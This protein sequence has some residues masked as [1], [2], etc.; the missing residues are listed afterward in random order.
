M[1]GTFHRRKINSELVFGV[2]N[3]VGK[4]QK[5]ENGR[6]VQRT[7]YDVQWAFNASCYFAFVQFQSF[8]K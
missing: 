6:L 3:P 4:E 7:S 2:G 5:I 1:K 8:Q